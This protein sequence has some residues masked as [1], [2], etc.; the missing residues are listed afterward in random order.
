MSKEKE[1][2]IVDVEEVYSKSE[3]FV[4]QNR[5]PILIGIGAIIAV[6]AI[7]F[8][9]EMRLESLEVEAQRQI[10]KAEQYFEQDSLQLAIN[11]DDVNYGFLDI[12]DNYSGTKS[13]NLA[14]YYLGI[15]Y[16]H[17]G[18]FE[19]AIDALENFSSDDIMISSIAYGALGDAHLELGDVDAAIGYYNKAAGN[20]ENEFT[21]PFYLL[22]AAEAAES[23][24]DY[25]A[26]VGYY[27]DIKMNFPESNEGKNIDKYISRASAYIN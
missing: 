9:Y 26:A 10:F 23:V 15:S 7:Y 3:E 25:K 21:S 18:Q 11:G 27:E 17:L 20:N 14:Q 13:A 6:I 1:E 19:N 12:I 16:L 8:G 24:Q 5:K 22:K 4:I 2:V